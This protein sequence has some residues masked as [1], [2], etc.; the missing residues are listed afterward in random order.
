MYWHQI[1]K[2]PEK[3]KNKEIASSQTV[4]GGVGNAHSSGLCVQLC[5]VPGRLQP[6][7]HPSLSSAL[8][9]EAGAE[10]RP[11]YYSSSR[12]NGVH[13]IARKECLKSCSGNP[14]CVSLQN[15]GLHFLSYPPPT[16]WDYWRL[17][18]ETR[19]IG[20]R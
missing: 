17:Y 11:F 10:G 20:V 16:G 1:C 8:V 4:R 7:Q 6:C 14:G 9:T 15:P 19:W 3:L 2:Y 12:F 18:S 13:H 5:S